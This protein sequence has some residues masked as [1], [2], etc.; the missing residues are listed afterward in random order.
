[1][2]RR[3]GGP[4]SAKLKHSWGGRHRFRLPRAYRQRF[5]ILKC[6]TNNTRYSR[7]PKPPRKVN[8]W[9]VSGA[10]LEVGLDQNVL[11]AAAGLKGDKPKGHPIGRW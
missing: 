6:W 1:M 8:T 7:T 9:R 10:G 3:D 4:I 2:T 5:G 11:D